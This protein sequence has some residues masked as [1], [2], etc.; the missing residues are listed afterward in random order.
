MKSPA[1]I[2][3]IALLICSGAAAQ[4]KMLLET[5]HF[6]FYSN[7]MLNAHLFLYKHAAQIKSLKVPDDSLDFYLTNAGVPDK[8][9]GRSQLIAAIKYY[10]DSVTIKDMLF[11]STMRKFSVMLAINKQTDVVD[12]QTQAL[13]HIGAI[14]SFFRKQIWPAIDSSNKAWVQQVKS[15]LVSHEEYIINRLQKLYGDTMPIEKIRVD[16]G[17]YASWAG[18]YSYAQGIYHIIISSTGRLN[19]GHLGVEIVFHEASHFII[20]KVFNLLAE[21]FSEKKTQNTRRQTWHNLLFYTTGYV[22]NEVYMTQG[23]AF[24]PYYKEAKFEDRIPFKL[25]TD[26]F[27]LYWNPYMHGETTMEEA[28]KKV[29]AYIVANEK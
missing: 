21:Y 19:Q 2:F 1:K 28:L 8:K 17:V 25:S 3:I 11:D 18:A 6:R 20:D 23:I 12:W 29:V 13:K 9:S 14:Q 10:R 24:A 15:D 27:A 5:K 16:L 26:A 7:P 4:D 22:I